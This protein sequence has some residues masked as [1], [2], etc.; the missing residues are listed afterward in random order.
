LIRGRKVVIE[1]AVSGTGE[2]VLMASLGLLLLF[3]CFMEPMDG[4]THVASILMEMEKCLPSMD[5][6]FM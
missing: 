6:R 3:G 2:L 1:T 5:V 4:I